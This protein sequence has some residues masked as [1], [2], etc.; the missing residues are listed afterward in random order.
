MRFIVITMVLIST[1]AFG[2][3]KKKEKEAATQTQTQQQPAQ[4]PATQPQE[5]VQPVDSTQAP[6]ASMILTDHYLKKYATAS[7]W[8]D[9]EVA[10]DA[11]YDVIIENPGIDSLIYSLAYFYY[12][13]Q[14][15]AS[16]LLI[17]QDL[18]NRDPKN[19]NYLEMA[20]SSAQQLGVN[21]KA[22]QFYETL[23]L[24]NDN[25]RT[26][27]QVAFLQYNL[28][29]TS[30]CTTSIDILLAKPQV[31]TEKATFEDAK[32][33]AKEYPLKVSVLNLKGLLAL[34]L[35][36]KIGAKKAFNDAL[37]ISPDFSLA[38]VNLEKTK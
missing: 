2:Q 5:Q 26:L 11:L 37:A 29:R 22:L 34:E 30:E 28:K 33:V 38:K 19:Q 15:Y 7:R 23:Y 20:G 14:K 36:D 9:T 31:M 3:K 6:S 32:G 21:D 8:N 10:K 13:Q 1:V 35:K 25:I 4:Q 16:S 24:I 12:D 18:L 27:Y 17:S